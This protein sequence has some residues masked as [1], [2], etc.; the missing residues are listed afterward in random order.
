MQTNISMKYIFTFFLFGLMITQPLL[1]S[2][3]R[4][5]DQIVQ[6][7]LYRITKD[8]AY[9]PSVL[10]CIVIM[11]E[12]KTKEYAE[13]AIYEKHGGKC[14]GD[15]ETSPVLDR[16]RVGLK[17]LSIEWYNVTEDEYQSYKEFLKSRK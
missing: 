9:P 1:L 10:A 6:H 8:H 2:R 3:E 15:P 14:V 4:T 5:D 13:L 16:F 17:N 12:N 7:L 11:V